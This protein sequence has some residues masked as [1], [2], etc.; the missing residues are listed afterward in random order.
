MFRTGDDGLWNPPPEEG[1]LNEA[2]A[3]CPK[4]AGLI[5]FASIFE[6]LYTFNTIEELIMRRN[7]YI[8]RCYARPEG[9]HLIA[10]CIDLDL[11]VRA[12]T[13]ES[14]KEELSNAIQS[15]LDS[16]DSQNIMYLFPRPVPFRIKAEYYGILLIKN[17]LGGYSTFCESMIPK[18]GF[19]AKPCV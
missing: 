12:N 15:Y 8:L 5:L 10:V 16:L 2:H 1:I 14:A 6:L 11:I 3:L 4:T 9:D 13:V 19:Q 18:G 7:P 17:I